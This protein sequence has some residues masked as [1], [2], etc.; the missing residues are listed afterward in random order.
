VKNS[1]IQWTDQQNAYANRVSGQLKQAA[2]RT[3]VSVRLW[4]HNRANGLCWCTRCRNWLGQAGFAVDN[5]RTRGR[6]QYC[7][8]CVKLVSTASRYGI[9]VEDVCIL[10][11][12]KCEICERPGQKIEIDHDHETGKVRGGLCS[13]CN[14]ALGQ[15]LDSIEML[16]KAIAYLEVKNGEGN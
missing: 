16:K 2:A 8:S 13:R 3:G 12:G 1:S 10:T 4:L 14:G 6:Q 11:R 15:F 7:K 9:T 5:S